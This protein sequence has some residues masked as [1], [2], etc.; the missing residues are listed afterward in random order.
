MISRN[1]LSLRSLKLAHRNSW[2]L[3]T[4][5]DS[6][7]ETEHDWKGE[8]HTLFAKTM[9]KLKINE[10]VAKNWKESEEHNTSLKVELSK[11]FYKSESLRKRKIQFG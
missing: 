10:K 2:Q 8:Y 7:S 1:N 3:Q 4:E 11:S 9:K 6:E 5:H